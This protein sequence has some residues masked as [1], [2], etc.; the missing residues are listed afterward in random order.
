M[1]KKLLILFISILTVGVAIA[2]IATTN[3]MPRMLPSMFA[4]TMTVDAGTEPCFGAGADVTVNIT[5]TEVGAEFSF[6]VF[7]DTAPTVPIIIEDETATGETLTYLIEDLAVGDYT[8]EVTENVGGVE[9]VNTATFSVV[10]DVEALDFSLSDELLCDGIE[11]TTTVTASEG[12]LFELRLND[13]ST[14]VLESNTT[15]VFSGLEGETSYEVTVTDPCG[16]TR[17]RTFTT[18]A[19]LINTD[20]MFWRLVVYAPVNCNEA[21]YLLQ[22][23]GNTPANIAAYGQL[24]VPYTYTVTI[25]NPND[26]ANPTVIT[27]TTESGNILNNELQPYYVNGIWDVTIEITDACG[28]TQTTTQT[29]NRTNSDQGG[30]DVRDLPGVCGGEYIWFYSADIKVIPPYRLVVEDFTNTEFIPEDYGFTYDATLDAYVREVNEGDTST[31]PTRL[32]GDNENTLP[33]GDYTIKVL[34]ECGTG[35]VSRTLTIDDPD[36]HLVIYQTRNNC[37]GNTSVR[38]HSNTLTTAEVNNM[39]NGNYNPERDYTAVYEITSA[40]LISFPSDYTGA[41]DFKVTDIQ[42]HPIAGYQYTYAA[43]QDL[44]LGTYTI[45]AEVCG[46]TI[47]QSFEVEELP[48]GEVDYTVNPDCGSFS[49]DVDFRYNLAVP[50]VSLQ[51][52][53]EETGRWGRTSDG[54]SNA[55][56]DEFYYKTLIVQGNQSERE[57]FTEEVSGSI[58]NLTLSGRYRI[59]LTSRYYSTD[60]ISGIPGSNANGFLDVCNQVLDEFEYYDTPQVKDYYVFQCLD[61]TTTAVIDASGVEPI[62]YSITA[63]NGEALSV[64]NGTSPVFEGLESGLYTFEMLDNCGNIFEFRANTSAEKLPRI[65]ANNLCEDESGSLYLNGLTFMDISWTKGTD[66]TVLATGNTLTFDAFDPATDVGEY[67]ATISYPGSS[68][69]CADA[70][71]SYNITAENT[72]N[73][74]AGTGQTA[75]ISREDVGD[76]VDLFDYIDGDY[77]AFGYW[78]ETTATSSEGLIYDSENWDISEVL[79]GTYTFLYTVEGGCSGS[80]TTTVTLTINSCQEKTSVI[81]DAV[82]SN[83]GTFSDEADDYITFSVM[84]DGTLDYIAAPYTYAVTASQSG[85]AVEVYTQNND[86]AFEIADENNYGEEVFFRIYHGA[87]VDKASDFTITVTANGDC[88]NVETFTLANP[89]TC[90]ETCEGEATGNV[91]AY[92]SYLERDANFST[93]VNVTLPKFDE[94][95]GR[96]LTKAEIV[97]D[98]DIIGGYIIENGNTAESDFEPSTRFTLTFEASN[99]GTVINTYS[100]VIDD[101]VPIDPIDIPAGISVP[102]E[103]RWLG[104]S[105]GFTISG[106]NRDY[107]EVIDNLMLGYDPQLNPNWVTN[108]TG[109]E[110]DDDDIA[111]VQNRITNTVTQ[112]FTTAADLANFINDGNL[113]DISIRAVTRNGVFGSGS[114]TSTP[115]S[116]IQVK[117][118]VQYTYDENC[119]VEPVLTIGNL[120]CDTAGYTVS[121]TSSAT[122]ISANAGTVDTATRTITDVPFGTTLVVTATNGIDC[123]TESTVEIPATCPTTCVQPDLSVGQAVCVGGGDYTVAYTETTA[124]VLTITGG[125]DNGNGTITGTV[126]TDMVVTATNGACETVITIASPANCDD[127]CDNVD[128]SVGRGICAADLLSYSIP[129]VAS[130]GATITVNSGT[131]DAAN[132]MIVDIPIG[133]DVF[134]TASNPNCDFEQTVSAFAPNECREECQ[135]PVL[136]VSDLVCN[137]TTYSLTYISDGETITP[138]AGTLDATTNTINDIPFGTTLTITAQNGD[139]CITET[140]VEIPTECPTTCVLPDLS[141]G[142]G[143][144]DG[145]GSST[146]TAT[147][148]EKTGAVIVIDGGTDNGD[149]TLTGTVGTDIIVTAVNG[150]CETSITIVSPDDCSDPCINPNVSI[151]GTVCSDDLLTYDVQIAVATGVVITSSEGTLN[152]ESTAIEGIDTG[153]PVDITATF[154]GCTD[155]KTVTVNSPEC[156]ELCQEPILTVGDLSCDTTGYTV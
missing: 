81:S 12:A 86:G 92:T 144:C 154:S 17:V 52:Y 82:C 41:I 146:Y 6:A 9:S 78:E 107:P 24:M 29:I 13:G 37:D 15:G 129:Y 122:D 90:S 112:E 142:Q 98:I 20:N 130:E 150:A 101:T 68:T 34:G 26:A 132:N 61:G 73:P 131:V 18:R 148:I 55:N 141:V 145:V 80:D 7:N 11:L 69:D 89:G 60:D 113:I 42:T 110:T 115:R 124:A 39:N 93:P 121:Y 71:L 21:P 4:F 64:D 103:G 134:I 97:Y 56:N 35:T 74:E 136:T 100:D 118:T 147:Y 123:T 53:N 58:E 10:R 99:N 51:Y 49:V 32:I 28:N 133:T 72:T 105:G 22:V 102:A 117:T 65:R 43:V 33:E 94:S 84:L 46:E 135:D 153:T 109:D 63:F 85:D 59:V 30:L 25:E 128:V 50:Q 5:E 57:T 62:S 149:G 125:V 120:T 75:T 19:D 54:F 45:E 14:A 70:V 126:G 66:P 91:V 139:T 152:A 1:K 119:C 156:P 3:L 137:V 111:V 76:M 77:D 16:T 114:F 23:R 138:S 127:P 116:S 2:T 48:I 36:K 27:G 44:T 143:F 79:D 8:I 104:D 47:T 40:K 31:G 106:M 87:L 83:A 67:F 151:G 38:I 95:F 108:L 88:V 155:P 140:I 96:T